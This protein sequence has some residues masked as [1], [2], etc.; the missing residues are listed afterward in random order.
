MS[1]ICCKSFPIYQISGMI[2][3]LEMRGLFFLILFYCSSS[4]CSCMCPWNYDWNGCGMQIKFDGVSVINYNKDRLYAEESTNVSISYFGDCNNFDSICYGTSYFGVSVY[5]NETLHTIGHFDRYNN[6]EL[7]FRAGIICSLPN[8]IGIH[9]V[10][11][12][13]GNVGFIIR[14]WPVTNTLIQNFT[15]VQNFTTTE[16]FTKTWTRNFTKTQTLT[17]TKT[18]TLTNTLIQNFTNVQN[19]TTT[20]IFTKTWTRNFTKTQT[21]TDTKTLTL[22]NTEV[23]R[24]TK[25]TTVTVNVTGNNS[26]STVEDCI[27]DNSSFF[28]SLMI[29]VIIIFLIYVTIHIS[30]CV[31]CCCKF[32]KKQ[33]RFDSYYTQDNIYEEIECQSKP[34]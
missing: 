15:N 18:L 7:H 23:W 25:T 27:E 29:L 20:E 4:C 32:C 17:D 11:G 19:F 14:E 26:A 3:E 13:G 10:G 6:G 9:A 1:I 34:S 12:G 30:C 5:C 16:I 21:L 24:F 28:I 2:V 22:T 8:Q 33:R 31:C